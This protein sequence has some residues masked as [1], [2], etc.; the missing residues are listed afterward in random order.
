MMFPPAG[1]IFG[2]DFSWYQPTGKFLAERGVNF[3]G[4]YL[5]KAEGNK[6]ISRAEYDDFKANNIDVFFF[7]ETWA[8]D[9]M[10]LGYD[11]G[12]EH[13]KAA[14]KFLDALGLPDAVVHFNV[15][16]DASLSQKDKIIEGCKGAASVLG[17]KRVGLYGEHDVI[18][19]AFDAN[20]I[21]YACQ[22]YAWSD[23]KWE[24]RATTRQW[25]NGQWGDQVDFQWAM[26]EDFGQ[27]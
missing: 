27:K 22:T 18:K 5:W 16:H 23:G 20:V 24:P 9:S 12:V 10:A 3:V 2:V 11:K 14:Q 15:D 26:T 7:Y 19:W 1:A 13:A 8:E 25:S 4:N 21:S 6:G 17:L